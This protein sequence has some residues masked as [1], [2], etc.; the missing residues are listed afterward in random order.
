MKSIFIEAR[1]W[2][3]KSGGNSYWSAHIKVDGELVLVI[4]MTYGYDTAYLHESLQ[5]LHQAGHI[6]TFD[7]WN[8]R[9]AGFH[10]YHTKYST[11]KNKMYK[12][13]KESTCV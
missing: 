5:V 9:Q 6:P 13:E 1:E 8:L 11:T 2:F 3:D 10:I 12:L 4:P 7:L